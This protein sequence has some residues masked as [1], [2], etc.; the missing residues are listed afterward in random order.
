[1]K[2]Q[3]EGEL[4][5]ALL[6]RKRMKSF[7][8]GVAVGSQDFVQGFAAKYQNVFRRKSV[9]SGKSLFGAQEG[10]DTRRSTRDVFVFRV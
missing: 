8:T 10:E 4:G 2:D 6:L 7:T 9:R 1:V 5:A 3:E